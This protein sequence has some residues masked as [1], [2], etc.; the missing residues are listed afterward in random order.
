MEALVS[1]RAR[2]SGNAGKKESI[3]MQRDNLGKSLLQRMCEIR[4]GVTF[5][6]DDDRTAKT[7]QEGLQDKIVL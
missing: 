7:E 1:S 6:H 4:L 3:H 5:H 2:E